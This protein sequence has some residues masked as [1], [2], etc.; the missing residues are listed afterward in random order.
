M[1]I[2][3]LLCSLSPASQLNVITRSMTKS[4]APPT[5]TLATRTSLEKPSP[6]LPISTQST[7]Y[8]DRDFGLNRI[9]LA[10]HQDPVLTQYIQDILTNPTLHPT[11]T[12]QKDILYKLLPTN[13]NTHKKLVYIP[14]ILVNQIIESYHDHPTAAHFG[15]NRTYVKLKN[16]YYWPQMRSSIDRYIE[17]CSPCAQYNIRRTKSPGKLMPIPSP[18]GVMQVLGMDYWGPTA[19]T[20]NNN[21]YVLV[22][23]DYLSKFVIAKP[24]SN[25]TAQT[26][27]QILVEE[28]ILK[29]GVP[30][31]IITDNGVH[32]NNDLL[33]A[34]ATR[35]GFHHIKSTTYHPQTNGQVERF[36]AT[37]RPQLAKLQSTHSSDWDDFL[38]AVIFA[39]NTG[40]HASTNLSP[41]QMMFGREPILPFDPPKEKI[42][43]TRPH[44]YWVQ[45]QALLHIY[46]NM[47]R[48]NILKH[49]IYSKHR[50]DNNRPDPTYAVGDLVF[51]TNTS[52]RS[53]LDKIYSGPHVVLESHHPNYV[54][55]DTH[56]KFQ[57]KVHISK[58]RPVH[59]RS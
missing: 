13:G 3:T 32:F 18:E 15:P 16:R 39:Y 40:I 1:S 38:S 14:S 24:T 47:A 37:F 45:L 9:K 46:K 49:Q 22:I 51:S 52:P 6:P 55:E 34:I 25:N 28:V 4:T 30:Q 56:S 8:S 26:T 42:I 2:N 21:R 44:D 50:Y 5:T 43:M 33:K 54:I 35:V 36:N 19:P 59:Q 23:T 20:T 29:Y 58:L 41:F 57:Q 53:K 27:A 10:Q 31:Q 17:S 48:T 11:L 12:V 7:D